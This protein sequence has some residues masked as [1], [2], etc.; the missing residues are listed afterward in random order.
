M[1]VVEA[2]YERAAPILGVQPR[3][4]QEVS[5]IQ[6]DIEEDKKQLE[7]G[8]LDR[9]MVAPQMRKGNALKSIDGYADKH[10]PDVFRMVR[11]LHPSGDRLQKDHHERN[12]NQTDASNHQ[13]RGGI[14]ALRIV[15]L[16]G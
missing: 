10:C 8:K 13:E 14:N 11:I 3:D 2:A 12:E 4:K 6:Q 5:Q 7:G 9:A 15:F 16:I 1:S